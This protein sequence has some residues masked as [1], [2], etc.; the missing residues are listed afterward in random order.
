[1]IGF[2]TSCVRGWELAPDDTVKLLTKGGANG[3]ELAFTS[4]DDLFLYDSYISIKGEKLLRSLKHVSL[5]APWTKIKYADNVESQK[6]FEKLRQIK[7]RIG[8][9]FIVF[10]TN[11]VEDFGVLKYYELNPLIENIPSFDVSG[12]KELQTLMEKFDIGLCFDIHHACESDPSMNLSYKILEVFKERLSEVHVSGYNDNCPPVHQSKS[13]KLIINLLRQIPE[14]IPIIMESPIPKDKPEYLDKELQFI[15]A[16][17]QC[18][19]KK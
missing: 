8:A 18:E 2:S 15:L 19:L 13:R 1:M 16:G 10:H 4:L 7:E 11:V 9:R 17:L 3:I 12:L 6:V 5:H 14:N